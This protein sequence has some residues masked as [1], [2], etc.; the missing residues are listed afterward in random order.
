MN[1]PVKIKFYL[2]LQILLVVRRCVCL[3][4]SS[5]FVGDSCQIRPKSF[6]V[7]NLRLF[8]VVSLTNVWLSLTTKQ[9]LQFLKK[10]KKC[11]CC[12]C[13]RQFNHLTCIIWLEVLYPILE[14]D[15]IG[16]K[17]NCCHWLRFSLKKN[18]HDYI[19]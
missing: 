15:K 19:F 12:K 13:N 4:S 6:S 10:K 9:V 16:C 8:L 14:K 1:H 7:L 11:I 17:H 3:W 18:K 2:F 5:L